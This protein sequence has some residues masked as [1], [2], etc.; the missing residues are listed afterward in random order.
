M[1][2]LTETSLAEAA[3]VAER[4]RRTV[5]KHPTLW[6]GQPI[7][8]TVSA[9]VV[10]NEYDSEMNLASTLKRADEALYQAKQAGRNRVVAM[11]GDGSS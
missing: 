11:K 4:L 3:V 6:E 2:L 1:F 7:P 10:S 5:L 8:C 9:G